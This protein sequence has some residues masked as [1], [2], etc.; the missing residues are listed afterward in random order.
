MKRALL[1]ITLVACGPD[2]VPFDILLSFDRSVD[3][4]ACPSDSCSGIAK[5]CEAVVSLRV[6]DATDDDLLFSE[7]ARLPRDGDLCSLGQLDL[8]GELFPNT[9]VK[10]QMAIWAYSEETEGCP[11]VEFDFAGKHKPTPGV[12]TPAIAGQTYFRVGSSATAP[13]MLGCIN[14]DALNAPSCQVVNNPLVTAIVKN[15]D[16]D[17][18]VP[19]TLVERL[20][21]SVAEPNGNI[22]PDSWIIRSNELVELD[23]SIV[24]TPVWEG[25]YPFGFTETACVQVL[26]DSLGA[27]ATIRCYPA[28]PEDLIENELFAE[29]TLL[30]DTTLDL[31]QQALGGGDLP[32]T[33]LVVGKVFDHNGVPAVGVEVTPSFGTVQY[34]SADL[35]AVEGT[36]TSSS[37]VFVSTD[38]PY[39]GSTGETNF[40]TATDDVVPSEGVVIGGRVIGKVTV[41]VLRLSDIAN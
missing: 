1:A 15:F 39:A 7:C 16:T 5:A 3:G 29:G 27:V 20:T 4:L 24:G 26:T 25:E 18:E 14:T 28:G 10:I 32:N 38:A 40:W 30:D 31:I 33:G 12:P 23:A 21:V 34:L 22:V 35:S 2:S 8:G 41:I 17:V 6:L 13:L 11:A 37:G 36:R 19:N 9:M